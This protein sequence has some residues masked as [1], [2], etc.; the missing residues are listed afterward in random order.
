MRRGRWGSVWTFNDK[1]LEDGGLVA[2]FMVEKARFRDMVTVL[3]ASV[4]EGLVWWIQRLY[5]FEDRRT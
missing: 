4:M 1:R 3:K 2:G 5:G